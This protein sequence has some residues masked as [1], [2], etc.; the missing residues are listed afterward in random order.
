MFFQYGGQLIIPFGIF[1]PTSVYLSGSFKNETIS[2]N[3]AFA[4]SIPAISSNEIPVSGRSSKRAGDFPKLGIVL[5]Q[6]KNSPI[7]EKKIK[8]PIKLLVIINY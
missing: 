2:S 4:S 6:M 7:L 5:H 3:S 1:A 8:L